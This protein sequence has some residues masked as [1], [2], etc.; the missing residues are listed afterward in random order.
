MLIPLYRLCTMRNVL[1]HRRDAEDAEIV[2]GLGVGDQGLDLRSRQYAVDTI[3]HFAL[4]I[5]HL[6]RR[7]GCVI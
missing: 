2:W 6:L 4:R 5:S 1:T 7:A 3:P